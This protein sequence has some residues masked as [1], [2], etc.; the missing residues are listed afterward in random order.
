MEIRQTP[1]TEEEV[2]GAGATVITVEEA[3]QLVAEFEEITNAKDVDEFLAGYT[4]D[5][6]VRFGK[7]PEMRGKAELR[8]FVEDMFSPRLQ[9]FVCKKTLRLVNGNV[10][11]GTWT[12]TWTDEKTGKQKAGRG[13]EMWIMEDGNVST[14]DAV[15]NAWT[16]D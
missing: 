11:G 10:I 2:L 13:I 12:S 8:P 9:D 7:H 5:C 6:V 16:V 15:F 14:W 4:E 3:R 1:E